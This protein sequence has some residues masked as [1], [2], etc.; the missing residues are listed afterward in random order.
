M[1]IGAPKERLYA[2][3]KR[4]ETKRTKSE[5]AAACV[6]VS[7]ASIK[8]IPANN[9]MIILYNKLIFRIGFDSF[10]LTSTI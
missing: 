2:P 9:A 10:F 1:F 7:V 3:M 4:S 5:W 6:S 8:D